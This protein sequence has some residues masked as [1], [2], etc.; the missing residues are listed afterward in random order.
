[1]AMVSNKFLAAVSVRLGFHKHLRF[2]GT[3]IERQ[4][5]EYVVEVEEAEI[6]AKGARDYWTNSKHP[7]K[8]ARLLS[9]LSTS[10][11]Q[12]CSGSV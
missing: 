3:M 5:R 6:E 4:N 1:M 8:V 9:R 2:S 11:D 12:V 7:P 10:T